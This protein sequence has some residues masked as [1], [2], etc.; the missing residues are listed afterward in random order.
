[1]LVSYSTIRSGNHGEYSQICRHKFNLLSENHRII[2]KDK[3]LISPK[4]L[5]L[6]EYLN[7]LIDAGITSFKIEGRLKDLSYIK[8]VVAFY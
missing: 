1:M 7:Q 4:D 6:S 5:N 3:Y 8:N 2:Q